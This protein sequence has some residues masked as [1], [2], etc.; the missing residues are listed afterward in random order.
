MIREANTGQS[1]T[2]KPL[3]IEYYQDVRLGHTAT[4]LATCMYEFS[5]FD[6]DR[7]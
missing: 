1:T 6:N 2:E 3:A 7:V 5:H 4:L